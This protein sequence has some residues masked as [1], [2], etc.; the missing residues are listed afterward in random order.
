MRILFTLALIVSLPAAAAGPEDKI[1]PLMDSAAASFRTMTGKITKASYTK[2]IN[3]NSIENG[4]IAVKRTGQKSLRVLIQIVTPDP[5]AYTFQDRKAEAYFPNANRV[6]EYD[7]GKQRD[8]LDQFLLLGF[9]TSVAELRSSYAVSVTGEETVAGQKTARLELLPKNPK[10]KEYLTKAELWVSMADGHI[11]QQKF[12]E[13]A[14]DYRLIT[15]SAAKWD[16]E[17]PDAAMK[18][19]L[20]KGVKRSAPQK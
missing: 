3:D 16:A 19:N 8:L 12:W 10:A 4:S 11:V 6:E 20:P 15:Y 9:G 17:L 14:G 1:F 5:K 7:L 18:L 13:A 2:V